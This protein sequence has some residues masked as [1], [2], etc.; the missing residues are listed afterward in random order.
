MAD[1]DLRSTDERSGRVA[2]WVSLVANII[3][4]VGKG[5]IG[6]LG[7][8]RALVADAIHSAA[9]LVGSVA[10]MIGLR[11]A[12]RPPDADHPYGHGKAELISSAAVSV[13]LIGAAVQVGVS[14]IKALFGPAEE[15]D[16]LAAFAAGAAIVAKE[17]LYRYNARLGKKLHSRSLMAAA[18]DHRSDV[19][20]S[21][22][23]LIGI[24]V[25]I[26]GKRLGVGWMLY[27]DAASSALVAVLILKLG[28]EIA[29]DAT[30]LL[31]DRTEPH[32]LQP[33]VEFITRVEGVERIDELRAR[34]HGQ[35][36][37]VDVKIS[38]DADI[39]VAE[40]HE[41][42]TD[43]KN[44]MIREFPRVS[45]VLVH[46]NPYYRQQARRGNEE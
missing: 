8:S 35:Y 22:A 27:G 10:V 17:V 42:A 9:D 30:Q 5:A 46:V 13:L 23:A 24:V 26:T 20:S 44:R 11:V 7:G 43:V 19:I 34:D 2:A 21:A 32:E 18:M 25:S 28:I 39:S 36:V 41:I 1:F 38:V 16:V 37:I 45:D 14:G 4:M 29:A 15:P 12:Q 3:L 33:Y 31:M 6:I 40:G